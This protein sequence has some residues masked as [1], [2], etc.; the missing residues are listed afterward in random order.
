MIENVLSSIIGIGMYGV[1]SIC[2]FVTIFC[3]AFFWM[4]GLKKPYLNSMSQLPL[5]NES[6]DG[7]N[8]TAGQEERHE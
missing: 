6:R 4:L 7:K 1:I 5:E 2:I 8:K 3:V